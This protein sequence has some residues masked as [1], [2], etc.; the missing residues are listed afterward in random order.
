VPVRNVLRAIQSA[1]DYHDGYS[2]EI[3]GTRQELRKGSERML[4]E[5]LSQALRLGDAKAV[6]GP[7]A[8]LRIGRP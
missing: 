3:Q 5:V 8:R 4:D 6:A 7:P 1:D 2:N